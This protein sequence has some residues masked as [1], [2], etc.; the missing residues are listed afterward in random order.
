MRSVRIAL[1]AGLALTALGI[2]VLLSR[3]P[4]VVAGTGTVRQ[5]KRFA[6]SPGGASVC[7]AGERLPAGTSA[8][9][10]ALAAILGPAVTVEV[11]EGDRLLTRG[12]RGAGWGGGAVTVHV[13][14]LARTR[15]AV[16]VCFAFA[17]EHER[18][19]LLG[20]ETPASLAASTPQG[21]LPGRIRIE[22]LR[23]GGSS[24]WSLAAQVARHMG[25]GRA[26]AGTWIALL[27]LS[28]T[29]ASATLALWLGVREL[30]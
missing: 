20:E 22:Y 13:K 10:L 15:S 12:E 23:P 14:P 7:Q 9:R 6:S 8:L 1:A 27:V 21:V 19:S 28:L 16:T 17:G 30:R 3:S 4:P 11:L 18:V 29:A 5:E 24:W 26:W 25:L 2:G